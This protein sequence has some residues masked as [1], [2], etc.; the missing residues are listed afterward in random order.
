MATKA[1][2]HNSFPQYNDTSQ[3]LLW[4][5][6]NGLDEHTIALFQNHLKQD[7]NNIMI[8]ASNAD[9]GLTTIENINRFSALVGVSGKIEAH[10]TTD[11]ENNYYTNVFVEPDAIAA[12]SV[13]LNRAIS[14]YTSTNISHLYAG[15]IVDALADI[16]Q[17]QKDFPADTF[18]YPPEGL[19]DEQDLQKI[20]DG[21]THLARIL[22]IPNLYF[23]VDMDVEHDIEGAIQYQSVD[24]AS[25]ETQG[26]DGESC[27]MEDACEANLM[28]IAFYDEDIHQTC[29]EELGTD[30]PTEILDWLITFSEEGAKDDKQK[31]SATNEAPAATQQQNVGDTASAVE[32]QIA[33]L[34][35]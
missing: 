30:D 14:C 22:G 19:F 26:D 31:T 27:D 21:A 10:L 15:A 29:L 6:D 13:E 3:L 1:Q 7:H 34:D 24:S 35:T 32:Q 28:A 16:S 12:L 11:S 25:L 18:S 33:Q 23:A 5:I 2:S 8:P 9:T 17:S 4:A 20:A